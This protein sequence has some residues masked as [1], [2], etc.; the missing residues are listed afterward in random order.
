MEANLTNKLLQAIAHG[1]LSG[2]SSDEAVQRARNGEQIGAAT[3]SGSSSSTRAPRERKDE[4]QGDAGSFEVA[5]REKRQAPQEGKRSDSSA[6]QKQS[7]SVGQKQSDVRSFK[8]SSS[9]HESIL[10]KT[11]FADIAITF[12]LLSQHEFHRV[13]A[14]N[15]PDRRRHAVAH[16]R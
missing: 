5:K 8:N 13:V 4:R 9:P 14:R 10:I 12:F 11:T 16:Q 2:D 1:G 15:W 6:G 3:S 7:S